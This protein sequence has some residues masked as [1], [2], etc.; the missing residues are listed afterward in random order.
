MHYYTIAQ[1][2]RVK[3]GDGFWGCFHL[4]EGLLEELRAEYDIYLSMETKEFLTD[5]VTSKRER[6]RKDIMELTKELLK[7]SMIQ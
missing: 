4:G 6:L 2:F 3:V 7:Q 1:S 5:D